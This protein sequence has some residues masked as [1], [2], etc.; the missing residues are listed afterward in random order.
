M[1]RTA[2]DGFGASVTTTTAC[3]A[4]ENNM[5]PG[6]E[7]DAESSASLPG[8]SRPAN[9]RNSSPQTTPEC[10]TRPSVSG[11]RHCS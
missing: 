3:A 10:P 6:V 1:S 9:P 4:K 8:A 11:V 7:M 2:R 5:Q